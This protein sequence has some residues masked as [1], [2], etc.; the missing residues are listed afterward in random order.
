MMEKAYMPQ[1]EAARRM[2]YSNGHTSLIEQAREAALKGNAVLSNGLLVLA[3]SYAEKFN[4]FVVDGGTIPTW[5][6][7]KAK[8]VKEV[9]AAGLEKV[10]TM[11]EDFVREGWI[12]GVRAINSV[13]A[14]YMQVWHVD[15]KEKLIRHMAAH[16]E[17]ATA[18]NYLR[19]ARKAAALAENHIGAKRR[20][21]AIR[22]FTKARSYIAMLGNQHGLKPDVELDER[23]R[24]LG[25][26]LF[27][28][29]IPDVI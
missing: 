16:I 25:A 21:D 27:S 13:L 7:D 26:R 10:L 3:N 9:E 24:D 8:L 11:A 1:I 15:D 19:K 18:T 20:D 14:L 23:L 29:K 6:L 4:S 2:A 17:D 5:V 22:H 12:I 28:G